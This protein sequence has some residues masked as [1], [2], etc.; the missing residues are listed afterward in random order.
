MV[1]PWFGWTACVEH[2]EVPGDTQHFQVEQRV[3]GCMHLSATLPV[4]KEAASFFVCGHEHK[5]IRL[6]FRSPASP[7][8]PPNPSGSA[9]S[10]HPLRPGCDQTISLPIYVHN[11]RLVSDVYNWN[12]WYRTPNKLFF[13]PLNTCLHYGQHA[14]K[15]AVGHLARVGGR[16]TAAGL[17]KR[18]W[19]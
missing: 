10:P 5:Y 15:G 7:A 16:P 18:S 14:R 13:L 19:T 2:P 17:Q 6:S 11:C 8:N 4:V 1:Q 3:H 9:V 12:I